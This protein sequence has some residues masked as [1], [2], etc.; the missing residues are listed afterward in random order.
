MSSGCCDL[1]SQMD[2]VDFV[3]VGALVALFGYF[4]F[5]KKTREAWFNFEKWSMVGFG[6]ALAVF[7]DP[8][9]ALMVRPVFSFKQMI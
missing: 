8:F 4:L 2:P 5:V 7:P 6:V 9:M 1:I 3:R